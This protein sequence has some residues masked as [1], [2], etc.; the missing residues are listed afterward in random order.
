[1]QTYNPAPL[2]VELVPRTAWWSNVRSNVTRAEWE[3]CKRYA[4]GLTGGVC[5]ICGQVGQAQGDIWPLC[6]RCHQCKHMG[7]SRATMNFDQWSELIN[8]F[9]Q[10]N[11]W[12]D[13]KIE[14]YLELCFN[15]WEL[16]SRMQ[17]S[18]DVSFLT[19]IGIDLAGKALER[20]ELEEKHG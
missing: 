11:E 7:H 18:L 5:K 14:K 4:K 13:W 12:P 20:Q 1:M 9:K 17:W 16:R 8:H 6:P 2:A 10:V 15:I 19:T 3:K